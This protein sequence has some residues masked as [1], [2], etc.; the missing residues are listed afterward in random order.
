VANGAGGE[1]DSSVSI[2]KS[3]ALLSALPCTMV[4]WVVGEHIYENLPAP[5]LK[6]RLV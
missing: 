6:I 1:S 5:F 2:E 4:R 3:G